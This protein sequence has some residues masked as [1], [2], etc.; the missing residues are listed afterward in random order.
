MQIEGIPD[1]TL[2]NEHFIWRG[3]V[4]PYSS[5]EQIAF[6]ATHTRHSINAIP[7]GT[8]YESKLALEIKGAQPIEIAF[9]GRGLIN[10]DF[11]RRRMASLRQAREILSE[12][13]FL[14]RIKGYEEQFATKNY[15]SYFSYR[16]HG[17]GD[18]SKHG[19]RLF[20]IN[21]RSF[22]ARLS[23]FRLHLCPLR[24]GFAGF[25]KG[26][27]VIELHVDEDCMLYMLRL[28]FGWTWD[29]HPVREKRRVM[30]S[31]GSTQL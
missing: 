21:D 2:D 16:F 13:T 23:P 15:F 31:T 22:K 28:A 4:I 30:I 24:T 27:E 26:D 7:A 6:H 10:H 19:K 12:L 29:G 5:V 17:H 20:N 8:T 18:I 1:L 11:E 9:S 25:F 3:N 14:H